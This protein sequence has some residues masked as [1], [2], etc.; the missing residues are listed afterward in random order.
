MTWRFYEMLPG[1]LRYFNANWLS[2]ARDEQ[3]EILTSQVQKTPPNSN[4]PI[5]HDL[6]RVGLSHLSR[7]I[8][9][10]SRGD[11]P[12]SGG[13]RVKS[14]VQAAARDLSAH[15]LPHS[16]PARVLTS[17]S[18]RTVP[19]DCGSDAQNGSA[20]VTDACRIVLGCHA[21]DVDFEG[22]TT[23]VRELKYMN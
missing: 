13:T 7:L 1:A 8:S 11:S 21:G 2:S 12:I 3:F 14:E 19:A 10:S 9:S 6:W 23:Q 17:A 18:A 15:P 22:G 16:P 20:V 4:C 5:L